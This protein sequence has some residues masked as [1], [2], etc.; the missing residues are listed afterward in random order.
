ME[1]I[2]LFLDIEGVLSVPGFEP[3]EQLPHKPTSTIYP[4]Q[5]ARQFLETIEC[6]PWIK[7]FWISSWGQESTMWNEWSKTRHWSVAYPLSLVQQLM[8]QI[9]FPTNE[10]DGKLQAARWHSRKWKTQIVWIEDGFSSQAKDWA[11]QNPKVQLIDTCPSFRSSSRGWRTGIRQ[12]NINLICNA[13]NL[14]ETIE[15]ST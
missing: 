3:G 14:Q 8:A 7:P 4:V 15:V 1:R 9:Q 11:T 12:W 10:T 13:L 6:S 5:G 2:L